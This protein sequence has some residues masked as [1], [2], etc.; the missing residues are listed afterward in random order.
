MAATTGREVQQ[1]KAEWLAL[2]RKTASAHMA[3]N[4]CEFPE[5][6]EERVLCKIA[7][8]L[9]GEEICKAREAA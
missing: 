7:T 8:A 2:I 3:R 4:G 9:E 6:Y 1:F 5:G